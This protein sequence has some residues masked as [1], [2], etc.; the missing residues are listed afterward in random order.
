MLPEK[1]RRTYL[2][3]MMKPNLDSTERKSVTKK[4]LIECKK[5]KIC[6]HCGAVNGTVKKVAGH[7]VKL[8]H[9]KYL[10]YNRSTTK[11]KKPLP[12]KILYERTF[13]EAT[14]TQPH[15]ETA[16]KRVP[17]DIHPLRA[18]TL[19]RKIT[20]SDSQLL[21]MN[22]QHVRPEMLIWTHIPAPPVAIRPSVTQDSASTEDDITN[23][24]G[25]I[26]QV[27]NQIRNGIKKG[28]AINSIVEKWDY[29]QIQV[30]MYINSEVPNL[31]QPGFGK[32]IRS[33]VTRLKGKQGRF[34]GNLSGKRVDFTSR[35]VISPDPNLGVDEVAVPE[36]VA[37][38]LTYP[39][40]VS[41]YNMEKL[42]A[43]ILNGVKYPGVDHIIKKGGRQV[44]LKPLTAK[45]RVFRR[46]REASGLQIGDIVYR[47]LEDGDI[48]L[49]NR[50]PSLHKLSIMAHKVVVRKSRTFRLN[51]CVCTPYNADFDG[52]EMNLHIPQTEEA[53][54]EAAELMGVKHNLAT[55][56]DG[57]PIIAATQDFITAAYLLSSK[58][59]FYDRQTFSQIC[60][61]MLDADAALEQIEGS[62][63]WARSR[64]DLP[65]PTVLKPEALWTGKQV[66]NL[67]MKPSRDSSVLVNFDAP[68]KE[69]MKADS[70]PPDLSENEA[71]ICIRNSEIMC[72]RL[73]KA[74]LG[75]GK[76][77]SIFYVMMR[78]FGP[79]CAVHAMN[80][81]AKLSARWLSNEGF[82]IGIDDVYPD[83]ELTRNKQS[84]VNNAYTRSDDIITQFKDGKLRRDAGCDQEMTMENKISGVLNEVRQKAGALCFEHLSHWN[85]PIIMAKSGAKG[86]NLNVSQ[87]VA[88]VGQQIISNARVADGFQDRTLPHFPKA[89]RQP[90]SKGFVQSSFF[91]GLSPTEL[92][93]HAMSGR[94]GLVDTAVKTA[95]T[96]YMSRRLMKSLE[97]LSVQYDTTVRNS[98]NSIVQ[99]QF[100]EDSLDPV[101]MEGRAKPVN[102]DRTFLHAQVRNQIFHR[103]EHLHLTVRLVINLV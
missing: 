88:T 65:P 23:K 103:L 14:K 6:D 21:G 1:L 25:D 49:F 84:L 56:K 51:E 22:P 73:D 77:D 54:T 101:D 64:I 13:K 31:Q 37:A 53:R 47:H 69:F 39:E 34:R 102:F 92:I 85:S 90:T 42:R 5:C 68:G 41:V 44:Y 24:L 71:W 38:G 40:R 27:S 7:A 15:L 58:D 93:F 98:T 2:Q 11:S 43:R 26:V 61:H 95:E 74:I 80:R 70:T 100:G 57:T 94:E 87:M 32:P 30:A 63:K 18:L 4:I 50:Q 46:E 20:N 78:D 28:E 59:R 75:S 12:S 19:F 33:F 45:A 91:S 72:G 86:S 82:S 10:W 36:K 52:D 83:T 48:V 35:T 97:D 66:F 67:L 62:S 60:S 55:P 81:L 17:E 89:A 9:D 79:G 29:L 8:V 3:T 16:V 76:K 96:G 99:F